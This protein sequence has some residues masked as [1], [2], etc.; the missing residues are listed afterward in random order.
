MTT[1]NTKCYY[2][3]FVSLYHQN[4]ETIVLTVNYSFR[5]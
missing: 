1:W 4:T 3:V 2:L 5:V